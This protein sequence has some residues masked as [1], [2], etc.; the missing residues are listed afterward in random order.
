MYAETK[1]VADIVVDMIACSLAEHIVGMFY[2]GCQP[3]P[4][5][6][7]CAFLSGVAYPVHVI[8][9]CLTLHVHVTAD[10]TCLMRHCSAQDAWKYRSRLACLIK[11]EDIRS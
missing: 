9:C 4:E 6:G 1:S 3:G 7:D 11:Q 10:E 2:D 8:T 5:Q